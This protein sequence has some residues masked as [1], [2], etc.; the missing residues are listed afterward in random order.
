MHLEMEER[1]LLTRLPAHGRDRLLPLFAPPEVA[2]HAAAGQRPPAIGAC[3]LRLLPP[4]HLPLLETGSSASTLEPPE[5]TISPAQPN[6]ILH[7]CGVN[8]ASSAK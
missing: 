2:G 8:W 5:F 3:P 7:D 6:R 1:H 4:R